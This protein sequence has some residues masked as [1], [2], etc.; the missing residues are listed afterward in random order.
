[1]YAKELLWV[2]LPNGDET[3]HNIVCE[4]IRSIINKFDLSQQSL[5][6][7]H[8]GILMLAIEQ[9]IK[10]APEFVK[11]AYARDRERTLRVLH[12][13]ACTVKCEMWRQQ[14]QGIAEPE[15]EPD[16]D[17]DI[18]IF[19]GLTRVLVISQVDPNY[20]SIKEFCLNELKPDHAFRPYSV[21]V[22]LEILDFDKFMHEI[23]AIGYDA[24]KHAVAYVVTS[25][26]PGQPLRRW[27]RVRTREEWIA[28]IKQ[29]KGVAE[30]FVR[31]VPILPDIKFSISM[32]L[33]PLSHG[34]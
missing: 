4:M 7:E 31:R 14:L 12:E 6:G 34:C 29:M 8:K 25:S 24:S 20:G 5:Y 21:T 22:L 15:R 28:A 18:L 23:T 13:L 2:A 27:E 19:N 10:N 16:P 11:K 26:E 1:M 3:A 17:R 32:H 9:M 30:F 33:I